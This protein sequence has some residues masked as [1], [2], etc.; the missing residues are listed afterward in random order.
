MAAK[1]TILKLNAAVANS[2]LFKASLGPVAAGYSADSQ[3]FRWIWWWCAIF[4]GV[5]F[6]AFL[7][8][9]EETKYIPDATRD[10]RPNGIAIAPTTDETTVIAK[11]TE[12]S[13]PKELITSLSKTEETS[14]GLIRKKDAWIDG[15]IP[16]KPYSQRMAWFTT[17]PGNYSLMLRHLYQPFQ[18]LTFPAVTFAGIQ[19]AFVLAWVAITATLVSELMAAPPFNY[20]SQMIGL[21]SLPGYIGALIGTLYSGPF[22]DWFIVWR[23]KRNNGIFDPE[24]RLTLCFLPI[25]VGPVGIWIFGYYLANVSI[26][27]WY[28]F[29]GW[30]QQ[31]AH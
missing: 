26:I 20:S 19:Y 23:A 28:I 18:A 25:F 12:N 27:R 15:L 6:A 8:F 30:A 7:V 1:Q 13:D 14:T 11:D 24:M 2:C 10:E 31:P 17:S 4:L 9:Y 21:M 16:V 3:G 22:C 5:N 29:L